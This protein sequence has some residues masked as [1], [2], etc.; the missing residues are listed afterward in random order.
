ML[1]S[2][3][4]PADRALFVC[5]V[6]ACLFFSEEKNCKIFIFFMCEH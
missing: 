5:G 6:F 3:P 1:N 4:T 2:G